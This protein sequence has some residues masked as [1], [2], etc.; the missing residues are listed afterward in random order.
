MIALSNSEGLRK[1]LPDVT[2]SGDLIRKD[3]VRANDVPV[4]FPDRGLLTVVHLELRALEFLIE[5]P[6]LR[7]AVRRGADSGIATFVMEPHAPRRDARVF[8]RLFQDAQRQVLLDTLTLL[9]AIRSPS[10]AAA[11]PYTRR[12][13]AVAAGKMLPIAVYPARVEV[14]ITQRRRLAQHRD[15]C[16]HYLEQLAIT[17]LAHARPEVTAGIREARAG[18]ARAK[19]ALVALGEP[20]EALP[21]DER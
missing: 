3:D 21:D 11:P 10:E 9:C 15:T 7:L 16:S 1:F 8:V 6:V 13:W 5:E 2:E 12:D 19:A 20:V 14:I 18:I 4:E 17:G